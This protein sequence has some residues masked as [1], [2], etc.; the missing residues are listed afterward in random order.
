M[1]PAS[2]ENSMKQHISR[3]PLLSS[4]LLAILLVAC[5]GENPLV[6]NPTPSSTQT[7]ISQQNV[8]P[9][10]FGTNLSFH[11]VDDQIL[12]STNARNLLQQLHPRVLRMPTRSQLP[13]SAHI[14]LFQIIKNLGATPLIILNGRD[15]NPDALA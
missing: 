14:Q 12:T 3:L 5:G 11:T 9:Y 2:I 4:L 1:I 15:V 8:S 10:I 7:P 6:P 13:E